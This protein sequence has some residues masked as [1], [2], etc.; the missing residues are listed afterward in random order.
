MR[1]WLL[2]CF[3]WTGH[4]PGTAGTRF[5]QTAPP[6]SCISE[7]SKAFPPASVF[8]SNK[9][10][11]FSE[12]HDRKDFGYFSLFSLMMVVLERPCQLP[13]APSPLTLG[14]QNCLDPGLELA[15]CRLSVGAFSTSRDQHLQGT[16]TFL[17]CI[18]VKP[19]CLGALR[20]S[21]GCSQTFILPLS[22]QLR[23]PLPEW[24]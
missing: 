8:P 21:P 23:N 4:D 12:L 7:D 10:L 16:F 24:P 14:V 18:T 17:E 22:A 19:L 2:W 13:A 9:N 1:F 15:L 6:A 3:C 5:P 11:G 20:S